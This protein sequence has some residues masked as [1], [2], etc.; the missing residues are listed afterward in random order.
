MGRGSFCTLVRK[1]GIVFVMIAVMAILLLGCETGGEGKT[2]SSGGASSVSSP[3]AGTG[4]L[5]R[6]FSSVAAVGFMDPSEMEAAQEI[7][8][9]NSGAVDMRQTIHNYTSVPLNYTPEESSGGLPVFYTPTLNPQ[10]ST[11]GG[12]W[13]R[14]GYVYD[15]SDQEA[16][17][18]FTWTLPPRPLGQTD[19]PLL[20]PTL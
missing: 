4:G 2:R 6:E 17:V 13:D 14:L 5:V 15:I 18:D 10:G 16:Y 9:Q 12:V 19:S 8:A 20:Q 11:L 7:R 1:S 3:G